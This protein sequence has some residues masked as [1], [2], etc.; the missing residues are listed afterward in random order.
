MMNLI[1]YFFSVFFFCQVLEFFGSWLDLAARIA[2]HKFNQ[3][4]KIISAPRDYK[5]RDMRFSSPFFNRARPCQTRFVQG[6][7]YTSLSSPR[8]SSLSL[9]SSTTS[10]QR[11]RRPPLLPRSRSL[12]PTTRF[13]HWARR[14]KRKKRLLR[15]LQRQNLFF[16][17]STHQHA[18]A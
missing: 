14:K 2:K 15:L 12:R 8:A 17:R 13:H 11:H 6:P 9:H 16:L 5:S 18:S 3:K 10:Q 1:Y 4:K 7:S